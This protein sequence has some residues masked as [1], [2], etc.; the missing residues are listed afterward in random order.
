MGGA[1]SRRARR[2]R[3][4]QRERD[5]ID[6]LV[7]FFEDHDTVDQQTPHANAT[8]PPWRAFTQRYPT[9]AEVS[10]LLRARAA[11]G[12]RSHGQDVR[13]SVEGGVDSSRSCKKRSP[14][15]QGSFTT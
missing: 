1:S 12:G 3:R 14:T 15:I 2:A 4:P 9:D 11:R 7:P 8:K 13:Q 6:A 5:W 10:D